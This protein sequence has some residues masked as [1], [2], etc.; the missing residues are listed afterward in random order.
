[1]SSLVDQPAPRQSGGADSRKLP[2]GRHN[3]PREFV[4]RSQRDRLLDAM[5]DVCASDGYGAASVA[6]LCARAGVSRTTFSDHF[7]D[8][9][10]CFL[11]AYDAILGKF[12]GQVI[13]AYEQPEL[14][15][16]DR[17]RAALV[18]LLSFLAAEP[19]FA[20]MCILEVVAAGPRALERYMS[21][22]RLLASLVD[23]GRGARP[24]HEEL[25][26][27]TAVAVVHGGALVIRDQILAGRT[28]QLTELL[29]DLLYTTLV[30]YVGQQEAL[31]VAHV[32]WA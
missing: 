20:R 24:G 18:A 32:G 8:R 5:A 3:L 17:I 4:V 12:L 21:A 29:P 25:P 19:A 14:P 1:M 15:W 22:A 13:G 23:E 28:E 31:R 7:V 16:P 26:A 6:A 27:S 30:P 2:S 9:E 11:A 10:A